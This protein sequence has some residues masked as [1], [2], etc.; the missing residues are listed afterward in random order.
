MKNMKSPSIRLRSILG[1]FFTNLNEKHKIPF[2][3]PSADL[4]LIFSKK[5]N[6]KHKTGKILKFY[7]W[8]NIKP[9]LSAS[10]DFELIFKQIHIKNIKP[11]LSAF[12]LFG[13]HFLTKLNWKHKTPFIGLRPIRG[14]FFTNLNKNIKSPFIGFRPIWRTFFN[15]FKLKI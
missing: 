1:S 10:A 9:L 11:L 8:K 13:A 12:G 2:Y 4:G 7:L 5:L 6:K 3:R 14:A 15:K